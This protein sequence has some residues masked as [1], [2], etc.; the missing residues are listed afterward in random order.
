MS[1]L[2]FP[3]RRVAVI[4]TVLTCIVCIPTAFADDKE[5]QALFNGKDFTGWQFEFQKLKKDAGK[6]P[7]RPED[8]WS[9]K[10]G[11]IY[12]TGHPNGYIHTE[13]TYKHY[14]IRYDWQFARP[15]D[16]KDDNT[17]MGNSGCLVHIHPPQKVWPHCVEVQ[18]KNIDHGE[19]LPIP[20]KMVA[21]VHYD[22]AAR[23]SA[24]RPVGEWNTTEITCT[25]DGSITAMINGAKVS[26]GKSELTDGQIGLQSEGAEIHFRN[27]FLKQLPEA[28]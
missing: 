1:R 21:T 8:T 4:C 3:G 2:Y 6:P 10:D 17:F 15:A 16:L 5:L 26:W 23:N 12:C 7:P 19:L 14:V 28:K 11:V 22:R 25:A 13:K 24:V 20:R 27:I 18:G 9:V